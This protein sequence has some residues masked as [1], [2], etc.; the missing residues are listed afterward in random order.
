MGIHTP[1]KRVRGFPA[2]DIE[3][4]IRKALDEKLDAEAILRPRMP[5]ACEP[6]IDSLTVIE[7]ICAIEDILGTRLPP[8][9]APRG[10]YDDVESCV[11]GLLAET[12]AAWGR[13]LVKE[14]EHHDR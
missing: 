2:K 11:T 4:C 5:S 14:E 1:F 8:T 10:G 3:A 6:E 12:R 7:I 13:A 9:F